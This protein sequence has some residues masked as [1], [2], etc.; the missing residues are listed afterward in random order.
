M[1]MHSLPTPGLKDWIEQHKSAAAARGGRAFTATEV[2]AESVRCKAEISRPFLA[3]GEILNPITGEIVT[4]CLSLSN[5]LGR[6]R[7]RHGSD[8]TVRKLIPTLERAGLTERRLAW[9][10]VPMLTDPTATKPEYRHDA[11]AT[12]A[13]T[14]D[15]LLISIHYGQNH[16]RW[17]RTLVTPEGLALLAR[18]Q[19]TPTGSVRKPKAQDIVRALLAEG[20]TQA[21]V[22]RLTAMSKQTVSYHARSISKV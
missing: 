13:A 4:G 3:R 21:E 12:R 8:T 2:I 20:R 5:A 6:L 7:G 18:L 17:V 11:V 15:G 14:A 16:E 10:M 22:V 1:T 19:K 9:R